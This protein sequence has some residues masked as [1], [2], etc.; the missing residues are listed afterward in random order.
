MRSR[1][2]IGWCVD[3]QAIDEIH[4]EIY[5]TAVGRER[6]RDPYYR[7]LYRTSLDG[8]AGIQLLTE[9]NADHQ[10]EPS[11]VTNVGLHGVPPP[12][13]LIRAGSKVFVDT[14]STVDQPPMSVLR[15][16]HDGRVVAELEHADASR[17][18][19]TGWRSPVRERVTAADG[20]TD[21]YA[22]Y[23]A[24]RGRSAG[25]KTPVID[26]VYGGPQ[27]IVTPRNFIE[28]YRGGERG[29][30][31]LARLGFA[32]MTVDARGTPMRSRAF[33][34]AGYPE[35]TQ[36]GIDDHVAAIRELA[37][38]HPEMDL[39]RVGVY[40]WS[41]GGTFAAQAIFSRPAVLSGRRLGRRTV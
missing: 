9:P 18:F 40:G 17:L 32:V 6:G 24:P 14:W 41:W 11:E 36:V 1:A 21:L 15:S 16:T 33:R 30:S 35:F 5:F 28:A 25:T 34:D 37:Q 10:F 3:I 31:S 39:S 13:P 12:T 8:R 7:N 22:V 19:A 4:R 2:A 23:F 38:R 26:A 20:K 29:K 27:V